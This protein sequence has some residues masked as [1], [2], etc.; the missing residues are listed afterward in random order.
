MILKEKPR[1]F[2]LG[3]LLVFNDP[4]NAGPVAGNYL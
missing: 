1:Q 3:F 2:C 4:L